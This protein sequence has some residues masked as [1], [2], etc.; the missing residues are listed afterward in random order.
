ML[1]KTDKYVPLTKEMVF[2]IQCDVVR[3]VPDE[4]L[5][6]FIRHT[7]YH[8]ERLLLS[9]TWY[10]YRGQYAPEVLMSEEHVQPWVGHIRSY[11]DGVPAEWLRLHQ[12]MNC[13]AERHRLT[14][15]H[16]Y[17]VSK[18]EDFIRVVQGVMAERGVVAC[19]AADSA[20]SDEAADHAAESAGG[21]VEGTKAASPINN[22]EEG[23]TCAEHQ[24]TV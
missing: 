18:P 1:S 20:R 15:G 6:R 8:P 17:D 2:A 24:P 4:L 19:K 5:R 3:T 22:P 16:L 12:R 7:L 14:L 13:A 9:D 21:A 10:C 11:T 23:V